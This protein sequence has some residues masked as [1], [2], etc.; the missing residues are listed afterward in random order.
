MLKK[1]LLI[2]AFSACLV[3]A[4]SMAVPSVQFYFTQAGSSTKI[5]SLNLNPS[6]TTLNLSVWYVI[7]GG[8]YPNFGAEAMVGF[9]TATSEGAG[10]TPLDGKF[11]LN[12]DEN[13]AVSN[14]NTNYP[15]AFKSLSG[16]QTLLGADS[17][18][19]RPYGLDVALAL[20]QGPYDPG[21][22]PVHMFDISLKNVGLTAGQSYNLVLWDAMQGVQSTSYLDGGGDILRPG[23]S[24]TLNVTVG[25]VP[26]PASIIALGLGAI[27]LVRRRRRR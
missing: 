6:D 25:A 13:S 7:T 5:N 18:S 2:A 23:G 20:V 14:I 8:T 4:M 22:T 27:A 9:D 17:N 16:G 10:A 19:V 11:V 3:P 15:F 21:N 12:G 1:T 24:E 26:E